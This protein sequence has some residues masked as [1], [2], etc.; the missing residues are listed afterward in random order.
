MKN[1]NTTTTIQFNEVLIDDAR[2]SGLAFEDQKSMTIEIIHDDKKLV[3]W[4]NRCKID[5][6]R[7]SGVSEIIVATSSL[8]ELD[9]LMNALVDYG[10]TNDQISV[11]PMTNAVAQQAIDDDVVEDVLTAAERFDAK[12]IIDIDDTSKTAA[13]REHDEE[14]RILA[15]RTLSWNAKLIPA[16]GVVRDLQHRHALFG[17]E[18]AES[19]EVFINIVN[20]TARTLIDDTLARPDVPLDAEGWKLFAASAQSH[21]AKLAAEDLASATLLLCAAITRADRTVA[22]EAVENLL[23]E[24]DMRA[25]L[26]SVDDRVQELEDLIER[27]ESEVWI[28]QVR[29]LETQKQRLE[30][31]ARQEEQ[32]EDALDREEVIRVV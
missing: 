26:A 31:G 12:K 6:V 15:E 11:D 5:S 22:L 2:T 29:Q 1:I 10:F 28:D 20:D 25:R 8:T 17:A 27:A 19:N 21:L 13:Q 32:I 23:G 3:A 18:T 14:M 16:I 24:V 4:L 9:D 7:Y 30:D